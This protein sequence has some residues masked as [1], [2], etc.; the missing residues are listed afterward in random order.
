MAH[1]VEVAPPT[2]DAT[3]AVA[4]A[5]YYII[6]ED[7]IRRRPGDAAGIDEIDDFRMLPAC[8]VAERLSKK[9][10]KTNKA[11]QAVSTRW[12]NDVIPGQSPDKISFC[13]HFCRLLSVSAKIITA[14]TIA[15]VTLTCPDFNAPAVLYFVP[16][17]NWQSKD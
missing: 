6:N 17:A 9:S 1:R 14:V 7:V 11:S 8:C 15:T 10:F 16:A 4:V 2:A 5:V 13:A 12:P 3:P